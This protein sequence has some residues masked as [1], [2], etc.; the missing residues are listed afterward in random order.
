MRSRANSEPHFRLAGLP[1][2]TCK[3]EEKR[4]GWDSNP[5]D[6][7]TPPTRFPIALLRPT[8]T[9]LRERRTGVYQKADALL[10]LLRFGGALLLG[11]A[12]RVAQGEGGEGKQ[13]QG[14]D[15]YEGSPGPE[16]VL[17]GVGPIVPEL[18]VLDQERGQEEPYP[19]Q[20]TDD[21]DDQ[22]SP[23]LR[24]HYLLTLPSSS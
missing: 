12:G 23:C 21:G 1:R 4:R 9:P 20:E 5:R 11:S 13:C 7:L 6:G 24:R 10:A 3:Q 8:R 18:L 19:R 2:I 15:G 14:G 16:V 22:T 17:G